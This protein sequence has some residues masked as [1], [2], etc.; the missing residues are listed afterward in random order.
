MTVSTS[1]KDMLKAG[2]HFGHRSSA[3][4][5]KMAPYIYGVYNKTHIIDLQ[6]TITLYQ[7][8]MSVVY[9]I[10]SRGAKILLVGTKRSAR[11]AVIAAGKRC[12]MPYIAHRWYGGMLTNYKTIRQSIKRLKELE[13][14]EE[15][16][17]FSALTKKEVICLKRE[18]YKLQR[19]LGGVKDMGGLPDALFIIDTG[20]ENIAMAEAKTLGIPVIGI[21]DTNTAPDGVDF[22]IPGNDDGTRAIQLYVNDLADVIIKAQETLASQISVDAAAAKEGTVIIQTKTSPQSASAA[23]NRASKSSVGDKGDA[24]VI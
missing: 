22:I 4:N 9:D 13:K 18:L 10:A 8:A 2:V 1:I 20:Y 21:V 15:K 14:L 23:D 19:D 17:H 12:G 6:K 11:D 7:Q 16:E 24:A 3:W 5:P